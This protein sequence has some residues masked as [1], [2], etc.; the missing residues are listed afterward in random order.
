[1]KLT[2]TQ[3]VTQWAKTDALIR[4][5]QTYEYN[6]SLS[7]S[8]RKNCCK[9][10][11]AALLIAL[12]FDASKRGKRYKTQ[13]NQHFSIAK[14]HENFRDTFALNFSPSFTNRLKRLLLSS[15]IV[16]ARYRGALYADLRRPNQALVNA[17]VPRWAQNIINWWHKTKWHRRSRSNPDEKKIGLHSSTGGDYYLEPKWLRCWMEPAAFRERGSLKTIFKKKSHFQEIQILKKTSSRFSHFFLPVSISRTPKS[18]QWSPFSHIVYF[19]IFEKAR[20]CWTN[21]KP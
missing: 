12:C 2:M 21:A 6:F 8:S 14:K 11:L 13:D 1:M 10:A 7:T 5:R 17:G 16:L 9:N 15:S 4:I 3:C 18:A 19:Q 20:H